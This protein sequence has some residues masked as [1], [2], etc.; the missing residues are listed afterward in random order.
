MKTARN[1][2]VF[3]L[4][5]LISGFAYSISLIQHEAATLPGRTVVAG[6]FN[7]HD[8]GSEA[9]GGC[10][11]V[12]TTAVQALEAVRWVFKRLNQ[13]GYL[14]G[15]I[16]KTHNQYTYYITAL[17]CNQILKIIFLHLIRVNRQ[18]CY[19]SPPAYKSR[20]HCVTNFQVRTIFLHL[21]G[22]IVTDP[23]DK[24]LIC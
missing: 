6:L 13:E 4:A 19:R 23:Q 24:L 1:A 15:D 10:G 3:R 16:G 8:S 14:P 11:K 5:L 17:I 12:S 9:E 22:S 21:I 20:H 18:Q 2:I 7:V